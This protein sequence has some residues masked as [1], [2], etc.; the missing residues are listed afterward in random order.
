MKPLL[1]LIFGFIF[2]E[3]TVGQTHREY[4]IQGEEGKLS[5]IDKQTGSVIDKYKNCAV[6]DSFHNLKY[7]TNP[8]Y[9]DY[10]MIKKG[11]TFILYN[12]SEKKAVSNI[13]MGYD[14]TIAVYELQPEINE[15]KLGRL[16]K[17]VMRNH[18]NIHLKGKD[19][20]FSMLY[21]F[22]SEKMISGIDLPN[23]YSSVFFS[24]IKEDVI[25]VSSLDL[26]GV[27][28]EHGKK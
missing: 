15:D 11:K 5:L 9:T 24:L 27:I 4:Q 17:N 21:N 10:F 20:T 1:L 23:Y 13:D 6:I 7:P 25:L 26:R 8:K 28:N 16:N 18:I 19:K 2:I 12:A 14:F 22:S 3:I